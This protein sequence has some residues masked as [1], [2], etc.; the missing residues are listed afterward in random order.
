MLQSL[1]R[2]RRFAKTYPE[3]LSEL[4]RAN[5]RIAAHLGEMERYSGGALDVVSTL[6]AGL[7]DDDPR[8]LGARLE[9][10]DAFGRTGRFSA[11]LETY[12]EVAAKARKLHDGRMEGY[13]LMR[14]AS[15]YGTASQ[16][17]NDIFY[18]AAIKAC[19]RVIDSSNPE[20]TGF[21]PAAMLLKD[22]LAIKH[23][24]AGAI[25]RLI[26]TYRSAAAGAIVPVLLYA[27]KIETPPL[28]N[29]EATSTNPSDRAALERFDDQWIDV[30]FQ[31]D[32]DGKVSDAEVLRKSSRYAGNWA[33]PILAAVA[34]RRYAPLTSGIENFPRIER[35]SYT[36]AWTTGTGSRLRVR[37][38]TP[39]IEMIDLSRLPASS[40]LPA[41]PAP[42]VLPTQSKSSVLP[43]Q[44]PAPVR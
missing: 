29:R 2:N 8:I 22:K 9:L 32:P 40:V 27:P 19:N 26:A 16:Q 11:A 28:T 4:L 43:T 42:S 44:P 13:A 3:P 15:A 34:G 5:A 33:K 14:L 21:V 38:S 36:A 7:P 20:M 39:R 37:S 23:G 12:H 30:T 18:A 17:R 31:I 1:A 35:Y 25:D 6:K 41:Q 10:G 24:D